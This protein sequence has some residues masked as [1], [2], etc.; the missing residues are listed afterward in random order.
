[1]R[2]VGL[3]KTLYSSSLC[4]LSNGKSDFPD[5]EIYL[6][7]R[8]ERVKNSGKSPVFLASHLL[9]TPEEVMVAESSDVA[10]AAQKEIILNENFPFFD[11]LKARGLTSFSANLNSKVRIIGHHHAHAAAAVLRSPFPK[12]LV[13]VMDGAGSSVKTLR[14][15]GSENH[16]LGSEPDNRFEHFSVYLFDQ[17]QLEPVKKEFMQFDQSGEKKSLG[18]SPGI[19]YEN[20]SKYIFNSQ[21]DPGKVMGL[22][23]FGEGELVTDFLSY[24]KNLDWSKSFQ[25]KSKTEWENHPERDAFIEIAATAQRSFEHYYLR[26]I[27]KLR[28]EFPEYEY[29]I[30]TG[31]CALNCT[32]NWKLQAKNI[33]REIYVAFNPGDESIGLG[34]ASLLWMEQNQKSWK[35]FPWNLQNSFLGKNSVLS[36]DRIRELFREYQITEHQDVSLPAARSISSGEII[37]WFQGRSECGPR[38]LG[39]RSILARPDR[40]NLKN[41]LNERIKFRENFRPYGCTVLHED[42]GKYFAVPAGF[43]NPFMSFAVPVK[44]EWKDYLSHVTHV[45][46]TSRMQTLEAAQDDLFHKLLLHVRTITGN[47]IVLNTSLNVMNEPILETAEDALRFFQHSEVDALFIG[48]YEIRKARHV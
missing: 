6:S 43:R 19:F 14:K 34:C 32:A 13:V 15:I 5:V 30:L 37:A 22:A 12:A 27:E 16:V 9:T 25:G 1:M 26:M 48:Q 28:D 10:E 20:I 35:P 21:T 4:T 18:T 24:Q 3:G 7:E 2:Y 31:G 36:G 46:Q 45:D 40:T 17:G 8:F 44:A 47:G 29:L 41:Y 39:H 23:A 11:L 33:F 42:A 38:A